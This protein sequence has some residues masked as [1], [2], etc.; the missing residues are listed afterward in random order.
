MRNINCILLVDDDESDNF[1]HTLTIKET[2]ICNQVKVVT[3]GR[4]ALDYM[5]KTLSHEN[6]QEYPIPDIIFLDI[7]MPRM[8]GFDF[9]DEYIQLDESITSDILII[10]LTTSLNPYDMEKAMKYKVVKDYKNKP[11]TEE[12]L[13]EITDKYL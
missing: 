5:L 12:M 10:M 3:D 4:Y 13:Q 6:D 11:L 1:F 7:N 8:S 9:L 2:G